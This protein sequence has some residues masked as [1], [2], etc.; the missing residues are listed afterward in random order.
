VLIRNPFRKLGKILHYVR[1]I[2]VENMRA[3][4]MNQDTA[5]VLHV[6]RVAPDMPAPFDDENRV[7]GC[8]EA[9][10]NNASG[11]TGSHNQNINLHVTLPSSGR[12]S[13]AHSVILKAQ[14]QKSAIVFCQS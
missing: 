11:K 6:I 12:R 4:A 2:G 3:I 1:S 10:G 7:A 13:S 14:N 5:G 9:F 8:R